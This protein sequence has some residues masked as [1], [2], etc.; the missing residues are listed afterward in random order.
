MYQFKTK[1]L[2]LLF[3]K[4]HLFLILTVIIVA[5]LTVFLFNL[6]RYNKDADFSDK[7]VKNGRMA[8]S[9]FPIDSVQKVEN[10][11]SAIID[12]GR[13]SGNSSAGE[14]ANL[15]RSM[16][17]CVVIGDSVTEGLTVYGFLSDDQVFSEIGASVY[18]SGSLFK[19]AAKTYPKVAFFS[20]GMNDMGNFRGDEKAFAKKYKTRLKHFMHV[21]PKSKI[22]V[23]SISLP[24]KSAVRK[25][26]I[27]KHYREFNDA[28]RD[29]C[30]DM[31]IDFLDV[32]FILKVK[33]SLYAGDG[34]HVKPA[35]Y[36]IWLKN[37]IREANQ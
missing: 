30:N 10:R 28:I 22:I 33:P 4:K 16:A 5:M 14:I 27:L 12:V 15:R 31:N 29:M 34:I 8:V 7:E 23:N 26:P 2:N 37:M 36:S 24:D 32:T 11:I 17:G 35:Y 3:N 9:T 18:G 13:S 20:F 6:L 21:S 19:K 25:K 1:N